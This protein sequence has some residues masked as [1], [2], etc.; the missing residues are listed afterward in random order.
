MKEDKIR[1]DPCS[2][3]WDA[4]TPTEQGRHCSKCIKTVHNVSDLSNKEINEKYQEL[5]GNFCIRIPKDRAATTPKPWY[6]K[7]KY[8]AVAFLISLWITVQNH[9]AK[10]QAETDSSDN[11]NIKEVHFEKITLRGKIID[12]LHNDDPVEFATIYVYKD[13]LKLGGCFSQGDGKF[14]LTLDH[15]LKSTDSLEIVVQHVSYTE[16]K[17]QLKDLKEWMD[18]EVVIGQDHICTSAINITVK[19]KYYIQGNMRMGIM[20]TQNGREI[21][22]LKKETYDTKTFKSDELERYNLGR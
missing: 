20:I 2:E 21:Y 4:M 1:I 8:T 10:A 11:E 3:N 5:N 17:K 18:I 14:S 16:I 9:V 7:W 13:S 19:R 6:T 15:P 12:S 22:K